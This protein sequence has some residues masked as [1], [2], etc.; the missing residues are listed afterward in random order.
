MFKIRRNFASIIFFKK[1]RS[2]VTN[3]G[4]SFGSVTKIVI[5]CVPQSKET[6]QTMTLKIAIE[7]LIINFKTFA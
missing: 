1:I 2:V 3:F 7:I 4:Y 6:I 5:A